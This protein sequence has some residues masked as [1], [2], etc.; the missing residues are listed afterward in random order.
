MLG[1]NP[2]LQESVVLNTNS[3]GFE[4]YEYGLELYHHSKSYNH[5]VED[6]QW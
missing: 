3:D 2:S 4:I 5:L 6:N 1:A